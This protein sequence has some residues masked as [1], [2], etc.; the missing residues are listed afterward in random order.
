MSSG[1][2][3]PAPSAT[4]E[5]QGAKRAPEEHDTNQ[6]GV[7]GGPPPAKVAKPSSGDDEDSKQLDVKAALNGQESCQQQKVTM[8]EGG[9]SGGGSGPTDSE[10]VEA[11]ALRSVGLAVG[12]RLEV[13]WVLEEDDKSTEKVRRVR[14]GLCPR[15]IPSSTHRNDICQC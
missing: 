2:A 11:E 6:D 4:G 5:Q 15:K 8:G 9:G 14:C 1:A 12:S 7:A 3:G 13:M 10:R